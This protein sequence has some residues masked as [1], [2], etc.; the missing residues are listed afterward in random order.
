M[1]SEMEGKNAKSRNNKRRRNL[2]PART[3]SI[4]DVDWE[5]FSVS[6]SQILNRGGAVRLGATRD[7]GA[8]AIGV[9]GD[10]STPYTEYVRP[11]ED[12]NKYFSDL[13]AFFAEMTQA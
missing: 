8:W 11:E 3:V 12:I 9:Y 10:G 7:G 13:G 1:T 2:V 5:G 4:T 6:L